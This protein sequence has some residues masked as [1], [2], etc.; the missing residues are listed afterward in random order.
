[1][2]YQHSLELLEVIN[3]KTPMKLSVQVVQT[4]VWLPSREI[5]IRGNPKLRKK[6]LHYS[7]VIIII[8]Y[9]WWRS[10]LKFQ[11]TFM[12]S[13]SGNLKILTWSLLQCRQ[14]KRGSKL[15]GQVSENP[16]NVAD[17]WIQAK[18]TKI[19]K[20]Q[21]ISPKFTQKGKTEK[22]VILHI[23]KSSQ[24]SASFLVTFFQFNI[25]WWVKS[26]KFVISSSEIF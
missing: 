3:I 5:E 16:A 21:M 6:P 9:W 1:M 14:E 23:A 8:C 25:I 26:N 11:V 4:A 7:Y 15:H 2:L 12:I 17:Q 10:S 18:V 24:Q 19:S 13:K 20:T 22:S